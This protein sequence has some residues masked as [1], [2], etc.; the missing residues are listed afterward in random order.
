MI[1]FSKK[2]QSVTTVK[3]SSKQKTKTEN[4]PDDLRGLHVP[5]QQEQNT[6]I[7]TFNW[8]EVSW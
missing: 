4:V 1:E 3:K 6:V 5:Q 7:Q 2:N 8:A